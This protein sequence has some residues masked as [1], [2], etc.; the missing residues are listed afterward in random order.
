MNISTNPL[1]KNHFTHCI[2]TLAAAHEYSSG[3]SNHD[4]IYKH[5]TYITT[6]G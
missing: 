5:K 1:H 3:A 2:T 4:K 6:L